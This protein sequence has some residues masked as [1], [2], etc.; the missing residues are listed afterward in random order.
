MSENPDINKIKKQK[1]GALQID[2]LEAPDP[3]STMN[4][5]DKNIIE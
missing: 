1:G 2:P 3:S 4:I 5:G